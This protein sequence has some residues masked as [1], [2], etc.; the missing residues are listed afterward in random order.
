MSGGID[1]SNIWTQIKDAL[2]P[3]G[4]TFNQYAGC[5]YAD[6]KWADCFATS[7]NFYWEWGIAALLGALKFA[8]T[9]TS[10]LAGASSAEIDSA[11][12]R[13][14][15]SHMASGEYWVDVSWYVTDDAFA[16]G[17]T[18]LDWLVL[19]YNIY[20]GVMIITDSNT[21]TDGTDPFFYS[22]IGMF[23]VGAFTILQIISVYVYST[24]Q[25]SQYLNM[26]QNEAIKLRWDTETTFTDP[27]T[28]GIDPAKEMDY[29]VFLYETFYGARGVL[30]TDILLSTLV[31]LSHP[32]AIIFAFYYAIQLIPE[33]VMYT[34]VIFNPYL[35]QQPVAWYTL[36]GGN[37]A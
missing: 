18:I 34:M 16:G 20:I 30:I 28:G 9:N 25:G 31:N 35:A 7:K 3:N 27:A 2:Y 5:S 14:N 13:P 17:F 24:V 22:A 19:G 32:Y 12:N 11:N 37:K 36:F 21:E 4:G 1:W 23:V 15:T 10:A 33:L 6:P 26:K 29:Y 8:F